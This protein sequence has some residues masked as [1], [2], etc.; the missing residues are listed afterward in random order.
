MKKLLC[1]IYIL[2]VLSAF[3]FGEEAEVIGEHVIRYTQPFYFGF[4]TGDIEDKSMAI[5][6][7]IGLEF[8]VTDWL[9][10]QLLWNPGLW[11]SLGKDNLGYFSDMF[12]GIKAFMLGKD[13]LIPIL[14]FM[15]LSA[16]LGIK[17]PVFPA[18]YSPPEDS[19]EPDMRL[20][21]S[22]LRVYGDYIF[23]KYFYVNAYIEG[24]YYPSQ[25]SDNSAYNSYVVEHNLDFTGE[26]EARF[27]VP[28]DSGVTIKG[29]LFGRYFYAP[30]LNAA[31]ENSGDQYNLSAGTHFDILFRNLA[32]PIEISVG[33]VAPILGRNIN[34]IHR[35]SLTFRI[36]VN[37]AT[38]QEQE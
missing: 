31:N 21:G 27:I 14:H 17:M 9:N 22:A 30:F 28:F 10:L 4:Q 7:G 6:F 15:R 12:F 5:G 26:I 13:A 23:N 35:V 37:P 18:M 2:C 25:W 24:V 33:Y 20:W 11:G 32:N 1:A 3:A 34:P 38:E 16:A 29:G 36:Y 19:K 8:G